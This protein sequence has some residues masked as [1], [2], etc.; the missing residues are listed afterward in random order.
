MT[1]DCIHPV[2]TTRWGDSGAFYERENELTIVDGEYKT[3][4]HGE[5]TCKD[6]GWGEDQDTWLIHIECD[7]C[8]KVFY[9]Q[10]DNADDLTPDE[11]AMVERIRSMGP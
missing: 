7:K 8:E 11:E 1:S 3:T 5:W 6:G 10:T 9:S 4:E 2:L